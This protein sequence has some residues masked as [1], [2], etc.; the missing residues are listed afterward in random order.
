MHPEI[1]ERLLTLNRLFY[2]TFA[3]QFSATR[4]RL[5]SGVQRLLGRLEGGERILDLGCG[6]GELAQALKRRG[7]RGSYLGL[8]NSPGLLEEA[9]RRAGEAA[10]SGLR[11][12]QADLSAAGWEQALAAGPQGETPARFDLVF[13][14]A[15]LH[16]L[17]G[18]ELRLSIAR[19][20]HAL[21]APGGRFFL[22]NWQFLNSPR[23]RGRIQPWEQ[24]G[25]SPEQVEPGDYLLD[26]RG[27]GQGL[28]YVHHFD[29]AE[30]EALAGEAGF[31]VEESFYSDGE[32][33]NLGLYQVWKRV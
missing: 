16:H 2:Q 29:A 15:V 1:A 24:A 6:N 9:R 10:S 20:A 17:P 13:A 31:R 18:G 27:G 23:L 14:F 25:L 22:S 33:G 11:F 28:R 7:H 19:K 21:L 26:W 8:D 3:L 30:L 4:G 12:L 5:Q 32:S